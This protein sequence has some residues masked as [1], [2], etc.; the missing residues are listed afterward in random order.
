MGQGGRRPR[1]AEAG[2]LSEARQPGQN[3][4]GMGVGENQV[5]EESVPCVGPCGKQ[6]PLSP[7]RRRKGPCKSSQWVTQPPGS[8]A[9]PEKRGVQ[10]GVQAQLVLFSSPKGAWRAADIKWGGA[11]S[12]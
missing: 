3:V 10:A 6:M 9:T 8:L 12:V 4:R 7:A 5:S 1:S 11:L 2:I